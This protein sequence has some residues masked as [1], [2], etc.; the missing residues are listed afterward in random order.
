MEENYKEILVYFIILSVSILITFLIF[1]LYH[2]E[3]SLYY[4]ILKL[5]SLLE[6]AFLYSK[7]LSSDETR[8][9]VEEKIISKDMIKS[10]TFPIK[11]NFEYLIS[12][13]YLYSATK[14]VYIFLNIILCIETIR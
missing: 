2:S 1:F 7:F 8:K 5:I 6:I 11:F 14:T 10:L 4:S 13:I 3:N 9:F 12:N